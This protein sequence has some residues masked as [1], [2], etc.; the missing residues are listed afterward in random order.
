MC[1]YIIL[2]IYYDFNDNK[3]YVVQQLSVFQKRREAKNVC[4]KKIY[5][6]II[7]Q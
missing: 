2:Y 1:E 7:N 5:M 3:I 4:D 6:Y